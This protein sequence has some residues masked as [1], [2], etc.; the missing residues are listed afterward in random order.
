MK[1]EQIELNNEV[2]VK[3]IAETEDEKLILGGLRNHFF[4]G[5]PE[6]N[7]FPQYDGMESEDNYITAIKLKY[8]LFK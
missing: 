6:K 7:T 4:F 2:V 1:L 3:F 5:L 8:S